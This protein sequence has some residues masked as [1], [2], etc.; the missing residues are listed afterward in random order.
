METTRRTLLVRT[1]NKEEL[2]YIKS[3]FG[4]KLQAYAKYH[5]QVL[6]KVYVAL[7]IGYSINLDAKSPAVSIFSEKPVY[8]DDSK[9]EL[10]SE[11]FELWVF[12]ITQ[13]PLQPG[14]AYEINL[15]RL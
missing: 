12:P 7:D 2:D 11:N 1:P 5:S 8:K 4:A 6:K 3:I 10:D 13:G 9:E 15:R 14:I